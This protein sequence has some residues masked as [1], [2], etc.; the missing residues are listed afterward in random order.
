MSSKY[1]D[2]QSCMQVIGDVFMNPSLL[3][4]EDKY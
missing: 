4:L 3:D 2:T 1:Y